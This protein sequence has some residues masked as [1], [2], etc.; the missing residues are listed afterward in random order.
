MRIRSIRISS[1]GGI[2]DRQL[3]AD[4][5]M[6][7]VHGPNESGKTTFMEA[8]RNSLRPTGARKT[9]PAKDSTDS[10][11]VGY[12]ESGTESAAGVKGK[13]N[14]GK[15]PR[16]MSGISPD[17]YRKVFAM[18]AGD[19]DDDEMMRSGEISSKLL[20]I[21]G[22][23]AIPLAEEELEGIFS[24]Q[25]GERA[26]SQSVLVRLTNESNGLEEK[27]KEAR[28]MES[29]YGE[30]VSEKADL[31]AEMKESRASSGALEEAR[32]I[33]NLYQANAGNYGRLSELRSQ[34]DAIGM[35][36]EVTAEDEKTRASMI[37]D[38]TV[39]RTRCNSQSSMGYPEGA[40]PR[41]VE[42]EI[43]EIRSIVDGYDSYIAAKSAPPAKPAK[44]ISTLLI[45]GAFMAV[46]GAAGCIFTIYSAALIVVGAAVA[47]FGLRKPA[48][49][50]QPVSH[51]GVTAYESKVRDT[52]I[53]IGCR[54]AGTEGDVRT[55]RLIDAA[56]G[57]H[58]AVQRD[59]ETSRAQLEAAEA[60]LEGFYARFGGEEGYN[61][62]LRKTRDAA[63][64]DGQI[65][66]LSESLRNSGL[67]PG[68]P[69]C[70]VSEPPAE[71]PAKNE[72][73]MRIGQLDAEIQ[74][75]LRSGDSEKLTARL[76]E[77]ED[78]RKAAVLRGAEALLASRILDDAC[79][80]VFE[81]NHPRV[82]SDADTFLAEMT[83]GRYRVVSDPRE[84]DP[85]RVIGDGASK[86]LQQCSS[87]LRA[88]VL[89]SLKLAVAME[90][91]KGDI[92]MI[93][94]DVLLTFDTER[95]A[96]AVRALKKASEGMQILMFTC[97]DQTAMFCRDAG[98]EVRKL[99]IAECGCACMPSTVKVCMR[100]CDKTC[101]IT[102]DCS[103]GGLAIHME[104][105]CTK[106]QQFGEALSEGV[107][108]DD[109]LDVYSS[110]IM[111]PE[112]RKNVCFECLAVPAV[113]NACW[114]ETGM[115]SKGLSK[116]S[117]SNSIEFDELRHRIS[118]IHTNINP[119]CRF[120]QI[121]PLTL[122]Q[123]EH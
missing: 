51:T 96:G 9:Y 18:G 99:R 25:V 28:E 104:S 79:S 54:P 10:Y 52:M 107:S 68:N 31:E 62:N 32:R 122:S 82:F 13:T 27:L 106:L 113:F 74:A 33:W 8:I 26:N 70:P 23:E 21:P 39:A 66:T 45:A 42:A 91:G 95:K 17:L 64:I 69:V 6:T 77:N 34:R 98:V 37:Q 41:K 4:E 56:Y 120:I 2:R 76:A 15:I 38:A 73:P 24:K 111:S 90:L 103:D 35:F 43:R 47:V 102:A 7:V 93:L 85:L 75:I 71:D 65:R 78:A 115:I 19:L 29:R 58:A 48:A 22:G 114:L 3:D 60:R 72:I 109:I 50:P 121:C 112:V 57:T 86:T 49:A 40:D 59:M 92:P 116:R 61:A 67:D 16:C 105:D 84:K 44:G 36:T 108:M 88:Q 20:S 1:F 110:R 118:R 117:G 83:G 5:G 12:E 87:G 119:R 11:E 46:L 63:R 94:D 89:L 123:I 80:E 30:L 53:R 81:K 101:R 100:V 14:T 97:D 55:L